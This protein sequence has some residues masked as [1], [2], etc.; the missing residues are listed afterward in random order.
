M[1]DERVGLVNE[2]QLLSY[3][4]CSERVVSCDHDHLQDRAQGTG[5][6]RQDLLGRA[7]TFASQLLLRK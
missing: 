5:L 6:S 3:M 2:V 4:A 1:Q 7:L